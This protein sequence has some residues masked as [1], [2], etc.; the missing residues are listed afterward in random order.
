LTVLWLALR[1][2]TV[3]CIA[4]LF[5][6]GGLVCAHFLPDQDSPQHLSNWSPLR[7]PIDHPALGL[8]SI[9]EILWPAAAL[10]YLA[11][12]AVPAASRRAAAWGGGLA[13]AAFLAAMDWQA[14]SIPMATLFLMGGTW[15][16][17]GLLLPEPDANPVVRP[18]ILGGRLSSTAFHIWAA[19]VVA[20]LLIFPGSAEAQEAP[21]RPP[22]RAIPS[23][24]FDALAKAPNVVRALRGNEPG[25]VSNDP[26]RYWL[27]EGSMRGGKTRPVYDAQAGG[28][29]FDIVPMP[30]GKDTANIA[31]AFY[32]NFGR[33][34]GPN[35][36]FRVRWQQMFNEAMRSIDVGETA[37]KQAIVGSGD[38]PGL[39]HQ[40]SCT[41]PDIVVTTFYAFRLP[42]IYHSCGRYWPMYGADISFQNM[43]PPVDGQPCNYAAANVQRGKRE[44]VRPPAACAGWAPAMQW[45]D[46]ALEVENGAIDPA[47]GD[48]Y[49][50]SVVRVYVGKN[51]DG[52][53]HLVHE[54]DSRKHAG[55]EWKGLGL[56]VGNAA[57]DER[58]FGKFWGLPYMTGYK[59][60]H[61]QLMQTWYRHFIVTDETRAP[62]SAGHRREPGKR[63]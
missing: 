28:L 16:L 12:I 3:A 14:Q 18:N 1:V 42:H 26:N 10:G 21:R 13:L 41:V 53:L 55:T 47:K 62:A 22:P 33:H 58:F 60:G 37:I 34:F 56:F 7:G 23:E 59:G 49:V 25:F 38:G 31:G 29:R 27:P 45:Q 40:A 15:T 44:L 6:A 52:T 54:W 11:R 57:T 46:Y 61:T 20:T 35:E 30:K 43:Q 17:F 63:S 5:I 48:Q 36:R 32:F 4:A 2:R 24:Q 9:L 8:G 51:A 50:Y 39:R 19:T